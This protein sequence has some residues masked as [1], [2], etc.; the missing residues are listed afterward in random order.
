MEKEKEKS[1]SVLNGIRVIEW[2][3]WHIGP[4]AGAM[5]ADLGA[6]VIKVE[7]PG[8]GD[9]MRSLTH[10][11]NLS[12]VRSGR[13]AIAEDLNR[14]KK[15]I[16]I[17]LKD[18][19]G[20]EIM[21]RLVDKAD[22]FL[23][24]YL[25]ASAKSFDL[26]YESLSKR[27]PH[28]IYGSASAFGDKGP[29]A[30]ASGLEGVLYAKSGAMDGCGE[31]GTPP[32]NLVPGFADRG[33]AIYLAFGILAAILG[34]ERTGISQAVKT[35]GFG[36]MIAL[37]SPA[38]MISLMTGQKWPRLS[39]KK[40]KSPLYNIYPCKEGRWVSFGAIPEQ[41]FWPAF[42]NVLGK[43]ELANDPRFDKAER[44]AERAEEL[45]S[46]LNDLFSRKTAREWEKEFRKGNIRCSIVQTIDEAAND[47]QALANDYTVEIDHP[48]IGPLRIV[49][50]PYQLSETPLKYRNCAPEVGQDTEEIL[51]DICSYDREE[52]AN[53]RNSG[54]I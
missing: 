14:N 23:T 49:G 30:E 8:K 54:I 10:L 5:L 32:V 51:T 41:R 37:Q 27:N 12:I 3:A 47:P 1:M 24:N 42:C 6:E 4:G 7:A 9:P 31:P 22:V 29:E 13:M 36:A 48:V 11:W 45:N 52:I 21:L 25:E 2:A 16:A 39:V 18:P 33:G 20:R 38:M 35:S 44:R 17:D 40:C 15:S 50:F 34:R 53:M 26:D 46:L 19:T 43:P 28:I